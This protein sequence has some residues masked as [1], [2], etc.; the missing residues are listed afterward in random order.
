MRLWRWHRRTDHAEAGV[1][2]QEFDPEDI[3]ALKILARTIEPAA[4]TKEQTARPPD[5]KAAGRPAMVRS[6][7]L[8]VRVT[9]ETRRR[10]QAM[11][12]RRGASLA[13]IIEHAVDDLFSRDPGSPS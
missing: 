3:A 8:N 7:Q 2:A 9:S 5:Q 6:T 10:A 12:V 1:A 11:A 13:E 4:A